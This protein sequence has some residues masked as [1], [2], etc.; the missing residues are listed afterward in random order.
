MSLWRTNCCRCEK[1]WQR[2][3]PLILARLKIF[4]SKLPNL[5]LQIPPCGFVV[6][7]EVCTPVISS[8]KFAAVSQKIASLN[9]TIPFFWRR[10]MYHIIY[11][12]NVKLTGATFN[13]ASTRYIRNPKACK[14]KHLIVCLLYT[15]DAADE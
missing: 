10:L 9:L 8:E 6:K 7:M 11:S 4:L 2:L 13:N 1:Q 3:N 14:R 15:S 5:R 12:F